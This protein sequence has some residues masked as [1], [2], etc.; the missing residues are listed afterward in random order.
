MGWTVGRGFGAGSGGGDCD[1]LTHVGSVNGTGDI[2][3]PWHICVFGD[4]AFVPNLSSSVTSIDISDRPNPVIA[5]TVV[6]ATDEQLF[7]MRGIATDGDWLYVVGEDGVEGVF[8]FTIIDASDP[9]NLAIESSVL[10]L[11][12]SR[13]GGVVVDG[14]YCYAVGEAGFLLVVDVSDRTDPQIVGSIDTDLDGARH[15]V[16]DGNF[17]YVTASNIDA[18][19]VVDVSVPTAPAIEDSVSNGTTLNEPFSIAKY[20]DYLFVSCRAGDRVT[21]IDASDPSNLAIEHALHDATNLNGVS[22]IALTPDG[23]RAVVGGYVTPTVTALLDI[24][25]PT[26]MVILDTVPIAGAHNQYSLVMVEHDGY[27]YGTNPN[28]RVDVWFIEGCGA[29]SGWSV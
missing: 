13:G 1:D 26:A 17:C 8:V 28:V 2:F 24:S 27:F 29:V 10:D 16:K 11:G 15:L 4:Y 23:A 7:D 12:F 9:T 22:A 19:T 21:S 3:S 20:G 6:D 14:D 18:V 5:D 25:D